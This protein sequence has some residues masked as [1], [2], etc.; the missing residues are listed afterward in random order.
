MT[1]FTQTSTTPAPSAPLIEFFEDQKLN[2]LGLTGSSLHA[3]VDYDETLVPKR[4]LDALLGKLP[5]GSSAPLS[6]DID[7]YCLVFDRQHQLLEQIW[8][9][10]LRND[11][12]S[13]RHKGDALIG[14]Q[15]FEDSLISQEEIWIRPNE[16]DEQCHQLVFVMASYHNQPLRLA[17]K[18]I[19]T[20]RDNEYNIAH[21]IELSQ[22]DKKTCAII[23]WQLTRDGGDF[24]L[25]APLAALDGYQSKNS[26]NL[27]TAVKDW[28]KSH[29]QRWAADVSS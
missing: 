16:L 21:R 17:N 10:N 5:L 6:M 9:G 24:R 11:S 14:A 3:C 7:L 23:A 4:G 12:A 27:A 28:L 26:D 22:L 8:Y 20:F 1:D 15:C 18:G 25:S 29:Q 13:I 19:A 2:H